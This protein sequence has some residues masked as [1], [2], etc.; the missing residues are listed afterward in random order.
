MK[1]AQSLRLLFVSLDPRLYVSGLVLMLH[2]NLWRKRCARSKTRA[3]KL[4]WD[5]LAMNQKIGGQEF[6]CS[7]ISGI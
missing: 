7:R 1:H 4:S 5:L 3:F 6:A 2:T